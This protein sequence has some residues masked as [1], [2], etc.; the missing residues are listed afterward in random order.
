MVN[1][2][3]HGFDGLPVF[4]D[5]VLLL[6]SVIK[7]P[8][9]V[10]YELFCVRDLDW[11]RDLIILGDFLD[12]GSP[13][14]RNLGATTTAVRDAT[15]AIGLALAIAVS[16][17]TVGTLLAGLDGVESDFDGFATHVLLHFGVTGA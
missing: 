10:L 16:A 8:C 7:E 13:L 9:L 1:G 11:D 14:A 4:R 3:S 6:Y 5:P 17:A 2:D 12:S 15:S